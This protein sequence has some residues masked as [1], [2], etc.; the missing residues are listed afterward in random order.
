MLSYLLIIATQVFYANNATNISAE[1]ALTTSWMGPSITALTNLNSGF[2]VYEVDSAVRRLYIYLEI[3]T[4]SFV[5][6][7]SDIRNRGRSH[8]S[9]NSDSP[10][11]SRLI[12]DLQVAE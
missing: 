7:I 6:V 2:R 12:H 4:T 5:S 1:T 11:T 9:Y 3:L 10:N 8:V